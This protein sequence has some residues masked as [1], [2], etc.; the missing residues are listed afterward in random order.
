VR[1]TSAAVQTIQ[2]GGELEKV[3][4]SA[5]ERHPWFR[6][7]TQWAASIDPAE[8]LQ[9]AAG[10]VAKQ[11]SSFV[12][13]S[14]WAATELLI[15][16]FALFYFFRDRHKAVRLIERLTPF[17]H[18]EVER[19]ARRV[20]ETIL[21]TVYG[22]LLVAIVQGTLGG[23]MFWWLGLPAPLLW[24]VVMAL[25]AVVPVLGAFVVWVPA[26]IWL[27]ID[28]HWI[29][30]LVL[31]GWGSLIVGTIDNLL[32]PIFV[33]TRLHFHTLIMFVAVVGGLIA[34][35]AAGL[36]L[37][38]VILAVTDS[39]IELWRKRA[40]SSLRSLRNEEGGL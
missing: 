14:L 4:Q 36:I 12:T 5:R 13:A 15:T 31:T 18:E 10:T 27:A 17:T 21:A 3:W 2:E 22:T 39:L 20:A 32:Y 34:F 24:G 40:G 25:L 26:A 38:P 1:E 30:A 9:Q 35:G 37:G 8:Q 33:G 23:L 16:L 11:I 7:A 28:G 29:K 19:M 6:R